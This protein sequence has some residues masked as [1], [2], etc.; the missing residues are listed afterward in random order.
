MI[1][2]KE[3]IRNLVRFG[4]E[5][6]ATALRLHR[7]ERAEP[8]LREEFEALIGCL[9][10]A[11]IC[12][13]P[14]EGPLLER[15]SGSHNVG[16]EMISLSAGSDAAIRRTFEA[17]VGMGDRVVFSNPSYAMYDVY[18]RMFGA[19]ADRLEYDQSRVLTADDYIARL[20]DDPR[21]LIVT[22]PDQPT[23]ATLDLDSLERVV[24]AAARSG[25]LVLIDEAYHPFFAVTAAPL[26][27]RYDNLI[28]T[29]TFSKLY[30]IAGLRVGYALAHGNIVTALDTVKGASEVSSVAI[31]VACWLMDHPDLITAHFGDLEEGRTVLTSFAATARWGAPASPANFQLIQLPAGISEQEVAAALQENDILIKGGFKHPSLRG[32]VRITLCGPE[33]MTDVVKIL[34]R[35]VGRNEQ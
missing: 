26:V 20:V 22:N 28:V 29:R 11:D 31:R 25:T 7:N 3:T 19:E 6:P 23:G 18:T 33:N 15:V 12:F 35:F 27:P 9:T 24:A 32:C 34:K 14:D 8:F 5:T 2:P 16:P 10:P 13:Y 1:Q 21:L 30:G 17:Y 4:K